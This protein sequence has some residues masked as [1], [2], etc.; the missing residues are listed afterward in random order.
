MTKLE[1]QQIMQL[2]QIQRTMLDI[3]HLQLAS[4]MRGVNHLQH[5]LEHQIGVL[6]Q[7]IS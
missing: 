2:I 3:R 1:L 6:I 5:G 4:C 7:A